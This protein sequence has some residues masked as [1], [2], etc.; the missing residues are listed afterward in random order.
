MAARIFLA[1]FGLIS[2]P[3]GIYCFLDPAFLADFAG[4]AA[5][6]TTGTVELKAMYGGLQAGYGALA[7][8]GA[9]RPAYAPTIL[10]ATI[11][12]F[13]GLG[14]FRLMGALAANDFSSYTSQGLAFELG[15][16]AIAIFL[17]RSMTASSA[18]GAAAS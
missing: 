18:A 11:L 2:L 7:L 5:T 14:S 17:W 16:T 13:G 15:S 10:L 9:L 8:L 12:Q 1:I 4:V 3:Y 6:S